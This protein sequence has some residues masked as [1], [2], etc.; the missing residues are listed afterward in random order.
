MKW[1]LM[2]NLTKSQS[3]YGL[4]ILA[5]VGLLF[6]N[7]SNVTRYY[8]EKTFFKPLTFTSACGIGVMQENEQWYEDEFNLDNTNTIK[9]NI[10]KY[11]KPTFYFY[12]E[13]I[14]SNDPLVISVNGDIIQDIRITD[15]SF[16]LRFW[17]E[18]YLE[19]NFL[20]KIPLKIGVNNILV[21]TGNYKYAYH[22]II[23]QKNL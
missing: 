15:D 7:I 3:K 19:K 16:K 13:Y 6:F 17:K 11:K 23:T 18:F 8:I 2:F 9:I 1:K 20:A 14:N 5:L 4:I 10:S 12:G 22:V 21:S